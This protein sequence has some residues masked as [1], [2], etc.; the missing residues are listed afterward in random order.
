MTDVPAT[1]PTPATATAV[2]APEGPPANVL[3]SIGRF[4]FKWRNATFPLI[5]LAAALLARPVLFGGTLKSDLWLDA[6]GI[7]LCALGQLIRGV[8]VGLDYIKRGGKKKKVYADHL[9]TGGVFRHGRNPLYVGNLLQVA[10]L[11]VIHNSLWMYALVLPFFVF[12]Y[13]CI[14]AAEEQFLRHKFG[15]TYADY[16]RK[17]S[18]W[19]V[20]PFGWGR[21]LRGA[22]FDWPKLF[23]KEYGTPFSIATAALGLMAWESIRNVGLD[24]SGPR[25]L[26]L[27]LVWL[28][29]L[30]LYV[31]VR[32]LKKRGTLGHD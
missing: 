18:R 10:G 15:G 14:V 24:A 21:T 29:L 19:G 6:A 25:L 9:V 2:V 22:N 5:F 8:T 28:P 4:F 30:A 27:G 23:R 7:G 12:V 13:V 16:C 26:V 1:T 32:V 31:L 20:S 3:V 17:V 11:C